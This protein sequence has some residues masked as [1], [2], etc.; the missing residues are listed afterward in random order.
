MIRDAKPADIED[1]C[2]IEAENFSRP[3]TRVSFE[4]EL[5]KDNCDFLVYESD[6]RVA[7]YII[8]W[9]IL[10]EA[11]IGNIAVSVDYRRRGIAAELIKM[12][13]N[14]HPEVSTVFLEVEKTNTGAICLYEK[15][16][17][18]ETGLIRDYYGKGRDAQ[19]MCLDL[20][21]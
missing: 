19:R 9:Y 6:G 16:G 15:F 13:I 10:N 7:G 18:T 20:L 3:W 21:K 1:V 17:F 4:N 2:R 8:F 12:C 5:V 14:K 11:E